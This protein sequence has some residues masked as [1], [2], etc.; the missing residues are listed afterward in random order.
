MPKMLMRQPNIVQSP[1]APVLGR[2][3][4]ESVNPRHFPGRLA[5]GWAGSGAAHLAHRVVRPRV[6]GIV[7]PAALLLAAC[8]PAHP[9][10]VQGYVEGEFVYVASPRAGKLEKLAVSRGAQVKAGDLLFALEGPPEKD[11]FEEAQ[12]RLS[13]ARANLA[14][15]RKGK[16]Q[17][18]IRSLEAQIEQARAALDFSAAELERQEKIS[19]TPGAGAASD[20]QRARATR[21]QDAARLSQMEADLATA[22]LGARE[23]MVKALEANVSALE[24]VQARAWWELGEKTRLAPQAGVIFDTLYRPGEWVE[25]GRPVVALLPPENI[26]VRAFVPE[27]I[28]GTLHYGDKL[29]VS[30]DG[31]ANPIRG[32]ISFISPQAEYTPPVIYS[33]ESRGKLVFMIEAVFEPQAAAQLHP[34]QPVN[35]SLG[36]G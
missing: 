16:R 27:S 9:N 30:V 34:G 8:R 29:T 26:K 6:L 21:D 33:N 20:L 5:R 24:A 12:R 14:N 15:A 7:I 28:V 17:P 22:R 23:D 25:A 32:A 31:V 1:S 13:E 18:E 36:G 10:Q 4:P 35:V 3:N 11:A 2:S 19:R